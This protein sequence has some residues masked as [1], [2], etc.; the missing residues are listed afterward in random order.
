[1]IS[2]FVTSLLERLSLKIIIVAIV[3]LILVVFFLNWL[4]VVGLM[5]TAMA[6]SFLVTKYQGLRNFGIELI[7]LTTIITGYVY[8]ATPGIAVGLVLIIFHLVIGGFLGI[9]II[10]TIPEYAAIGYLASIMTT[11]PIATVGIIL[12]LGINTVNMVITSIVF[13][14]NAAR[15]LPWALTNLLL[16]IPLFLFVAPV[17]VQIL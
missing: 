11:M 3:M 15:H 16:N 8:G 5:I 13:G 1:M 2:R 7:A 14:A 4:V 9:Y 6:I 17:I 12:V 10:W